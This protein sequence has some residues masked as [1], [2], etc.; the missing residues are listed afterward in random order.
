MPSP[1]PSLLHT[2]GYTPTDVMDLPQGLEEAVFKA[3]LAQNFT[4][5]NATFSGCKN[6]TLT[7][8]LACSQVCGAALWVAA[9]G[10]GVEGRRGLNCGWVGA[11]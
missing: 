5:G 6:T 2:G 4:V 1:L 7:P 11:A 3:F 9:G 8:I 10:E